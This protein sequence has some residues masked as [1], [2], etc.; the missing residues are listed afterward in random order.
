MNEQLQGKLVEIL[1]GIQE[2]T[3]A[4]GDFAMEQLPEIAQTYVALGRAQT[5][6]DLAMSVA[7]IAVGVFALLGV[8]GHIKKHGGLLDSEPMI[9][10]FGGVGG[11]LCALFGTLWAKTA[12]ASAALVWMAPKVWLLRE[13]AGMM[14]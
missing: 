14:K 7:L 8:R 13:L 3:K 9:V 2:A 12:A 1:G 10:A 4:D 11:I 6:I 5:L